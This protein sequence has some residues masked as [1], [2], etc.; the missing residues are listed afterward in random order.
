MRVLFVRHAE[1]EPASGFKGLDL[2]RPLTG[3]G[4]RSM[5]AMARCLARRLDHPDRIISSQ[6]V[7]ARDT[8]ELVSNAFGGTSLEESSDLNP[9]A[10]VAAYQKIL[11]EARKRG[12]ALLVLVGHEPDLSSALSALLAGGQLEL[13]LKKGACADVKW[14]ENGRPVLRGLFD[15][16]L[17]ESV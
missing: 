7:R 3:K 12:D 6:A 4:R 16:A 9:G 2:D 13:K 11:G 17:I 8:A 5:K 14:P 10:G 15:P 1:A